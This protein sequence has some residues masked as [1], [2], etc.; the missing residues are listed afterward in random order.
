MAAVEHDTVDGCTYRPKKR[1]I[2]AHLFVGIPGVSGSASQKD[3]GP[4][5]V[6]AG[7]EFGRDIARENNDP[8]CWA[9]GVVP[10]RPARYAIAL[11]WEKP[12]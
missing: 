10:R 5:R 8:G 4:S 2:F 3:L 9:G 12:L 6:F 1:D 7:L 11:P